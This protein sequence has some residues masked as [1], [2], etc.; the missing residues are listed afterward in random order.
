MAPSLLCPPCKGWF[1]RCREPRFTSPGVPRH[2]S[3]PAYSRIET[4]S[5]LKRRSQGLSCVIG[6]FHAQF[7][8][9]WAAARPPGY[10]VNL[11]VRFLEGWAPAMAPG[12]STVIRSCHHEISRLVGNDFRTWY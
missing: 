6:N 4:A 3:P 11:Q 8:E 12:H 1:A 2:G 7:L 10:S 5:P 9:G